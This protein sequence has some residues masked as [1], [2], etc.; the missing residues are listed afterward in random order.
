MKPWTV[1]GALA[2]AVIFPIDAAEPAPGEPSKAASREVDTAGREGNGR[3]SLADLLPIGLQKRPNVLFNVY[4]EMT[5]AGR[6]RPEP[7]PQKPLTYFAPP[8][9]YVQTGWQVSGGERPPP[10]GQLKEVMQKALAANGYN[11]TTD[12]RQRP[13]LLIV[14]SYGAFSTDIASIAIDPETQTPVFPPPVTAEE[15]LEWLIVPPPM[16]PY[17]DVMA[18]RDVIERARFIGGARV[19]K[20]LQDALF[21]ERTYAGPIDGSP[22]RVLLHG[23]GGENLRQV[24]ELAFHS[25]YFVT[26]TAFDFSGVEKK[27]RQVLWQTRMTIETQ[28]VTMDE[29][30]KPLIVNTGAYLGRETPETVILKKRLDREGRVEIGEAKVVN[31]AA[32]AAPPSDAKK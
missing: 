17:Y 21:F 3:F 32:T 5:P 10:W 4:T 28:G 7:S 20:E 22:V 8:G 27:E 24:L 1:A 19:A 15:L 13:D 29:V 14:F 9:K 26:A 2:M 25:C 18:G 30:L 12:E 11:P 23:G 6:G 31:D 16:N